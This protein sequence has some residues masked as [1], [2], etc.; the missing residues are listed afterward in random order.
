[1][2][3]VLDTNVISA[4]RVRGRHPAVEAWAASVPLAEQ[5]VAASTI[6]EIERVRVDADAIERLGR[7]SARYFGDTSPGA[8][9]A[10]FETAIDRL[11][12]TATG[13]PD[14]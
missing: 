12:E 3:F 14:A 11:W 9:T 7:W 10:R 8:A 2:S 1:M 4:L 13:H 6:A 5:Y